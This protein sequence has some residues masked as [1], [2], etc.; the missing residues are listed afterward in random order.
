MRREHV[1]LRCYDAAT[2]CRDATL[3][4][5]EG[6]CL[7]RGFF[8][9]VL[10]EVQKPA[11]AFNITEFKNHSQKWRCRECQ[12]ELLQPPCKHCGKRPE[13]P[14]VRPE[15][16]YICES[17]RYPKC[18]SCK[19]TERPRKGQYRAALMPTWT[20]AKCRDTPCKWTKRRYDAPSLLV[21]TV[22]MTGWKCGHWVDM[23]PES[24]QRCASWWVAEMV[25]C[26]GS[27]PARMSFSFS[28][29]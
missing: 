26:W 27:F 9:C 4:Y 10:C 14:L 21:K 7:L 15:Q 16:D 19:I 25:W 13:K 1:T 12:R 5:L 8:L 17:C 24:K 28:N 11:D 29:S 22:A 20:C 23:P 6:S 3:S 2:C 18:D